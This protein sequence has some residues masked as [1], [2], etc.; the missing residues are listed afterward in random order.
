M[1]RGPVPPKSL[2]RYR[3]TVEEYLKW[4]V[5]SGTLFRQSFELDTEGM[6]AI[7]IMFRWESWGEAVPNSTKEPELLS[8]YIHGKMSRDWHITQWREG[9]RD[10]L[11]R[12]FEFVGTLGCTEANISKLIGYTRLGISI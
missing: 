2:R 1:N 5:D 10:G 7:E 4:C 12:P 8:L 9:I 11:F 6:S 3:K